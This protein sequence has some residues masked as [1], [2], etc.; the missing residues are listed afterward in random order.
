MAVYVW[1]ERWRCVMPLNVPGLIATFHPLL[2]PRI[3]LPGLVVK[4]AHISYFVDGERYI[5]CTDIRQLD[6]GALREAGYRRAVF[7]KDNC[8][9][10]SGLA[11]QS[12]R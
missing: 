4:G 6:F 10:S 1:E 3:I 12:R 9:V 11:L 2:N 5:E 7:D 8:L